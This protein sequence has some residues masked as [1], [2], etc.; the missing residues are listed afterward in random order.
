MIAAVDS[1]WGTDDSITGVSRRPSKIERESQGLREW[2]A[3]K[4]H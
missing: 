4:A 1:R 3:R 2:I